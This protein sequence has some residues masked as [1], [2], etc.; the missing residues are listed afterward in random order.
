MWQTQSYAPSDVNWAA[1]KI[2]NSLLK[3]YTNNGPVSPAN[4]RRE[5][6]FRPSAFRRTE[7]EFVTRCQWQAAGQT[8]AC[9][10]E[11]THP[12]KGG[13]FSRGQLTKNWDRHLLPRDPASWIQTF[14]YMRYI[15]CSPRSKSDEQMTFGC[16]TCL[17]CR[18]IVSCVF[19]QRLALGACAYN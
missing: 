2:C 11:V 8:S 19:P 14:I 5:L 1:K 9:P 16:G 18:L 12:T 7:R 15:H 6:E 4:C 3:F 17:S 10:R 13:V